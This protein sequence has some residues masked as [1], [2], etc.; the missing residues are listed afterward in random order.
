MYNIELYT[1]ERPSKHRV[2]EGIED[3]ELIDRWVPEET[4]KENNWGWEEEEEGD[5]EGEEEE[6]EV[7]EKK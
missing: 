7:V 4:E 1:Q 2:H 5:E 6:R 3:L